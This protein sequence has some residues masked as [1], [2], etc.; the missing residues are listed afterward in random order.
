MSKDR[1]VFYEAL[2]I[3]IAIGLF[4]AI[5]QDWFWRGLT[6]ILEMFRG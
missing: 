6:R 1:K 5:Q 3:T 4:Y 2:V